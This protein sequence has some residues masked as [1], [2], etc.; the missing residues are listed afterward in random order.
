MV[1]K[2]TFL[3]PIDSPTQKSNG[4]WVIKCKCSCGNEKY[5]NL[6]N[7]KS[8][9]ATSCGCLRRRRRYPNS[10]I[11]LNQDG[12]AKVQ[13]YGVYSQHYCVVDATDIPIIKEFRW[14]GMK[15]G[16]VFYA[17][18]KISS[19][20]ILMHRLVIHANNN[21]IVDHI[22]HNGLNNRRTN[23]R[24]CSQQ[25]NTFNSRSSKN[26][27]SRFVG[28]SYIKQ[29]KKWISYLKKDGKIVHRQRHATEL[30]AAQARDEAAKIFFGKFAHL[31]LKENNYV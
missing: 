19:H 26:S 15:R 16:E 13:L 18:S 11:T 12:T 17:Y 25:E 14:Y 24:I 7:Y 4:Q 3:I 20:K 23:L 21:Q 6:K 28:V 27:S 29:D 1:K 22:D 10:T 2:S 9:H 30:E 5:I 8:G 31:N